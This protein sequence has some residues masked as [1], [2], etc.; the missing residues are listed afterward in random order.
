MAQIARFRRGG[1]DEGEHWPGFVDALATLLIVTIFLVSLFAVA[2]YALG[3]ALSSRDA[4]LERLQLRLTEL[5]DSLALEEARNAEMSS[6][7]LLLESSLDDERARTAALQGELNASNRRLL[8]AQAE[9]EGMTELSESAQAEVEL[10]LQQVAALN[11]QLATLNA[12]LEAS[13]QRDIEQ[14]AQIENLSQRL[15]AALAQ[16]V[17][18]L[19][20]ARSEFFEQV[21][22]ALGNRSDIR[23]VGDR[24]IFESDVLFPVASAELSTEGRDGLR[25]VADIIKSVAD[26]IPPDVDWIIRVDGHTDVRPIRD[27]YPSNWHLSAERA[28]TVVQFFEDQGIPS[29]RLV[30]AGHGEYFPIDDRRTEEAYARNRRIELKL[31][32]R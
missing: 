10:L 32:S 20:R 8:I 28:I 18:E 19:A 23:I 25:R 7:I 5:A 21:Q 9:L 30:A 12:A 16:Q 13:E 26:T 11:Q 14:Q 1:G 4:E 29:N 22:A 31:D 27:P 17:Q 3:T 15:N 2:Q 6:T 24:F